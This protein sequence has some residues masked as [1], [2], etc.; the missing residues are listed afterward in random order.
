MV[1]L[2]CS[3]SME[4]LLRVTNCSTM[5]AC[6]GFDL[7]INRVLGKL[8]LDG[9]DPGPVFLDWYHQLV[10]PYIAHIISCSLPEAVD[11]E[12]ICCK[13]THFFGVEFMNLQA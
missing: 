12:A 7:P 4:R 8:G 2:E 13:F 9:R 3:C 1:M 6:K 10:L 11:V 5:C